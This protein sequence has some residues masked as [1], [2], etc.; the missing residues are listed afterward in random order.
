[1]PEPDVLNASQAAAFLGVHVQTVRR[2]A[3]KRQIP[4]FK[5]GT[6]WRFHK[7]ALLRWIEEQQ[8]GSEPASVP[9]ADERTDEKTG[10][11][12][13]S[14]RSVGH[15]GLVLTGR[16]ILPPESSPTGLTGAMILEVALDS[17]TH[18][19]LTVACEGLPKPGQ[20]MLTGLLVGKSLPEALH[21][22]KERLTSRYHSELREP[23]IGALEEIHRQYGEISSQVTLADMEDACSVLVI[24][25][26]EETGMALATMV[27]R[28]GCRARQTTTGADGL[29][30]VAEDV[31]DLIL[32]DLTVLEMNGPQFLTELRKS[33]PNLGVVQIRRHQGSTGHT[34]GW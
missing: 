30:M 10:E 20:E 18:R 28:F 9:I 13:D 25:D 4:G 8:L 1:M 5:V 22:A 12:A 19:V 15:D 34:V 2:L 17:A 6:D 33:Q 24:D 32:L 23:V 21:A 16:S 3:K 7:E 14:Q 27:E 26:E 31:P 11:G 29:T